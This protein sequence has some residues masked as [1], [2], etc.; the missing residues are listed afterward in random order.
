MSSQ[1]ADRPS[2]WVYLIETES[3][4][5]YTGISTDVERRFTEHCQSAGNKG[6]KF[7]RT[8]RPQTIVY[9]E[10]CFDR[11]AASKREAAIKKL[12]RRA[13]CQLIGKPY[14]AV[15]SMAY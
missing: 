4:K 3:G 6:A 5:L 15:K 14:R 8:E 7:F 11:S 12:S 9:R 2:W 13:K 1:Q 10:Q